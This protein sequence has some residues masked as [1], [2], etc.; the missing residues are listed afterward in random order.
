M[1]EFPVERLMTLELVKLLSL[2]EKDKELD[3]FDSHL[4]LSNFTF[5]SKLS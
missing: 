1:K 2:E 3:H 5:S 4:F